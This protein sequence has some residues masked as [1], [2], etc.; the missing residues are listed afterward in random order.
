MRP[1]GPLESALK[2]GPTAGRPL[3]EESARIELENELGRL[4]RPEKRG[5]P[6]AQRGDGRQQQ[7]V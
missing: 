6:P 1:E 5:R 4:L 7:Y 2:R 3:L